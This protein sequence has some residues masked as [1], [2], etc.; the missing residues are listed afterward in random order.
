MKK[1]LLVIL[2]LAMLVLGQVGSAKAAATTLSWVVSVTYQNVGTGPTTVTVDFYPEG[3]TTAIT[4]DPLSGGTLAAGAGA[5]FYIGSVSGI[6]AGFNGNAVMSSTQP[7]VATVVEFHQNGAGETVRMRMLSNGFQTSDASNQYLIATALL[8]KFS[9]TT[10]FSIQNTTSSAVSATVKLY[11][12]DNSGALASTI[13]HSI[14]AYSSKYIDMSVSADT[15]LSSSL[16]TFNGSAIVTVSSGTIVSAV[17][18]LYNNRDVGANFE[19]IPLSRVANTI[20]MATGLCESSSLDTYYAV[21]NAS[22]TDSASITVTYF[23][24]NGTTKTTDGPYSIGPGQKKSITTCAPSTGV[25]MHAFTGA[26]S[27]TSVGAPIAVIGKAQCSVAA[28]QCS[29]DKVDVF[30]IFMGENSGSSELALPFIR[31]SND[32]NYN[33]SSNLGSKQ[34][35]YL[36]IQNLEATT[37]AVDVEYYDKAGTLCGTDHLNIAAHA[38]GNSNAS[39]PSGVLGCGTMNA[40]EFGYYQDGTFGGSVLIKAGAANPTAKFIAIARVQN[41]GA[42]EDYNAVPVP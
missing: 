10:V 33:A 19:G 26:A 18:E 1:G 41:P 17:S 27:I 38:K 32:T 31:W 13:T 42:G 8:N 21:Q 24:T 11:D 15:G 37:S 6:S 14:P 9:R 29:A 35:S 20:Y 40:G 28:G 25:N 7:L 39:V 12:A 23:N 3:S 2:I 16:T 30:T 36:A 22:L 34:R 4:F 5:S